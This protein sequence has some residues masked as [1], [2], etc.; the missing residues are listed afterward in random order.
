VACAGSAVYQ[1]G[2]LFSANEAGY[3][4]S[5]PIARRWLGFR[6]ALLAVD[7]QP[8]AFRARL[9]VPGPTVDGALFWVFGDRGQRP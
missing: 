9:P 3:K 6:D 8:R 5:R 4:V 7:P 2:L 1:D